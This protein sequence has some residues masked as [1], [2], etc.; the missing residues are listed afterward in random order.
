MHR[1]WSREGWGIDPSVLNLGDNPP[2]FQ[3]KLHAKLLGAY[4]PPLACREGAGCPS[5]RFSPLLRPFA[6]SCGPSSLVNPIQ[7]MPPLSDNL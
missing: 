2:A 4:S 7:I 6:S 3:A 5:P 1:R